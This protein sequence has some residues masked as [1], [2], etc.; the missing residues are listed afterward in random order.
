MVQE[1]YCII[2]S[3]DS[4]GRVMGHR[5]VQ[6]P[7]A[8]WRALADWCWEDGRQEQFRR[9]VSLGTGDPPTLLDPEAVR[10]LRE[11]II[12][13]PLGPYPQAVTSTLDALIPFLELTIQVIDHYAGK[14]YT[15]TIDFRRSRVEPGTVWYWA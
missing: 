10:D 6:I 8:D 14:P 2:W 4:H 7:L 1:I 9:L 11:E 15:V 13:R 5:I 12:A 3:E